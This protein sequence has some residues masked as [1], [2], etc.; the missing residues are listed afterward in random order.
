[1]AT[2]NPRFGVGRTFKTIAD[3]GD[4]GGMFKA[5]YQG[6]ITPEYIQRM[7]A[8]RPDL[9]QG[10]SDPSSLVTANMVEGESGQTQQGYNFDPRLQSILSQ[11]QLQRKGAEGMEDGRTNALVG[12]DGALAYADKPYSYDPAGDTMK[13]LT[14]AAALAAAAFGGIG[15]MGHGPM[16]GLFGGGGAAGA[17]LGANGAFLGEGVASGVGAWDTAAGGM[18]LLNGGAAGA[19]SIMDGG[20]L[21]GQASSDAIASAGTLA[22]EGVGALIPT[23]AELGAAGGGSLLAGGALGGGMGSTALPWM[24]AIKKAGGG[25]LDFAKANPKLAG[26]IA[27]GLFGGAGGGSG[28]SGGGAPA[29]T[30]PMP[31]IERGNWSPTAKAQMMAVPQFGGQLP[32]TGNAN[33][34]LWRYGQ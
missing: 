4:S 17:E 7:A 15:M 27:G 3:L 31:T 9:F 21:L 8:E 24:D 22:P 29:Y 16:A 34:G 28:G 11:F 19:A 5:G 30:G 23:G 18:G 1:M 2:Y 6:Y 10:I 26:A 12:G 13:S 25:L 32:K 33:S 20:G 14:E